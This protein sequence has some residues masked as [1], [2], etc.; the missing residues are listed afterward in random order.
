MS[1]QQAGDADPGVI[2][3]SD[4]DFGVSFPQ[5]SWF[6]NL[7]TESVIKGT[8]EMVFLTHCTYIRADP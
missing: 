7:S 1:R 8:D 2:S 6:M 4:D 5:S 3:D